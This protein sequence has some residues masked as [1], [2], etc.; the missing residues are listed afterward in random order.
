MGRRA[1][2][3]AGILVATAIVEAVLVAC[4]PTSVGSEAPA[5]PAAS[6]ASQPPSPASAEAAGPP[7]VLELAVSDFAFST[8]TLHAVAGRPIVIHFVN[9][10]RSIKHNFSLW[11]D[12]SRTGDKLFH[13]ALVDGG[14]EVDYELGSLEAGEYYFECFPHLDFMNGHLVVEE[15]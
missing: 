14:Q 5:A 7:Q 12:E 9:Q 13:G 6:V 15:E 3:L 8:T 1:V 4:Q 2:Q 10:E 11:R